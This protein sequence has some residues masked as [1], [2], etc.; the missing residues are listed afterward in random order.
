MIYSDPMMTNQDKGIRAAV[1]SI[2]SKAKLARRLKISPQA[3]S[4]W[5]RVPTNRVIRV[6]KVT[7]VP[8]FLLRPDIYPPEDYVTTVFA[9]IGPVKSDRSYGD[10]VLAE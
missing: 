3:V 7:G 6:E 8:R 10:P 4:Q 1:S 2:G 9:R 5:K